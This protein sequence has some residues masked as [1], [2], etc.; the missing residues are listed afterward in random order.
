M[1]THF[2]I[3]LESGRSAHFFSINENP[4]YVGFLDGEI[5][6]RWPTLLFDGMH[7]YGSSSWIRSRAELELQCRAVISTRMGTL[8]TV[9]EEAGVSFGD[10]EEQR[11]SLLQTLNEIQWRT[12][13]RVGMG[14]LKFVYG[15]HRP[16]GDDL[17]LLAVLR[18]PYALARVMRVHG[19]GLNNTVQEVLP[20]Q[21]LEIEHGAK[22]DN[23]AEGHALQNLDMATAL[24]VRQQG[25]LYAK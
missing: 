6:V 11:T 1:K 23:D 22:W 9:I 18:L 20:R 10:E 14:G 17:D 3:P 16:H 12:A 7:I 2:T 24:V 21:Y 19:V 25:R 15:E 8:A 5:G 4:S 13:F